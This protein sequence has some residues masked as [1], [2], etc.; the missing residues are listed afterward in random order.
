MF[1]HFSASLY[2]INMYD[3]SPSHSSHNR[4]NCFCS[5]AARS[6]PNQNAALPSVLVLGVPVFFRVGETSCDKSVQRMPEGAG[7]LQLS[8][9]FSTLFLSLDSC[10]VWCSCL[11]P[12]AALA[13]SKE[14]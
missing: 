12:P 11:I 7:S 4:V 13:N 9:T 3:I 14:T 1:F 6:I 10:I 8:W 5:S 2:V